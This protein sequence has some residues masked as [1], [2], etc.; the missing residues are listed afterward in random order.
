MVIAL[1]TAVSIFRAVD[2]AKYETAEGIITPT[3]TIRVAAAWAMAFAAGP[4][5]LFGV[6]EDSAVLIVAAAAFGAA[7]TLVVFRR[8]GF[9]GVE[10]APAAALATLAT[11]AVTAVTAKGAVTVL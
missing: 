3:A 5:T 6:G 7:A 10:A 2:L 8:C 1:C 9:G 4:G 11:T